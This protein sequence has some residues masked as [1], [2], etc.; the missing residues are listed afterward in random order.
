MKFKAICHIEGEPK[1]RQV[2]GDVYSTV[3]AWV[4]KTLADAPVG[5][6]VCVYK[7]E[8]ELMH[9]LTKHAEDERKNA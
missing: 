5:T 8:E 6:T 1:A 4:T 9:K 3:S 2:F 7:V